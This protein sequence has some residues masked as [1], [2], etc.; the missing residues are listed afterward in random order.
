MN[1]RSLV[2]LGAAGLT[3]LVQRTIDLP[4]E[5]VVLQRAVGVIEHRD[6]TGRLLHRERTRNLITNAGRDFLHAQG[7]STSPGAN[8]LNYVALSN[9]ALT[10]IATATVLTNEIVAN[11]LSRAI[12]AYAHTGSTNTTTISKTFTCTTS[13]QACQKAALFTASSS[14]T[15]NHVLAFTQRTLQVGDTIAITFTITLG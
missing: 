15:M 7:Y 11:G 10:E 9:D 5:T 1:L 13:S 2:R 8:G 6:S 12:G 14:G 3:A 4:T